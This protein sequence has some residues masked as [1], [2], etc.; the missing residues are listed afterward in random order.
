MPMTPVKK[1]LEEQTNELRARLIALQSTPTKQRLRAATETPS[2]SPSKQMRFTDPSSR[3]IQTMPVPQQSPSLAPCQTPVLQ[4]LTITP[5][6][7]ITGVKA[8]RNKVHDVLV[9]ITHVNPRVLT[10]KG[11]PDSRELLVMDT[12]TAKQV[13]VTVFIDAANFRPEVGTVAVFRSMTTHEWNGGS[14]KAYA[15]RC[16]GMQWYVPEYPGWQW[17]EE[18]EELRACLESRPEAKVL[19]DRIWW[20]ERG[21]YGRS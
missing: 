7:N 12:S 17:E 15:Q 18:G 16:A 20:T 5:L 11:F 2:P 1:T 13:H 14:L 6:V 10:R 9:I 21:H 3:K 8:T 4:A 19:P